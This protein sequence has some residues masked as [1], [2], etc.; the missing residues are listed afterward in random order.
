MKY[1]FKYIPPGISSSQIPKNFS[2]DLYYSE[3]IYGHN[4]VANTS[5]Y[6]IK[7]QISGSESYKLGEKN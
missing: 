3:F 4:Y 6:S 7:S 5:V 1:R 2:N